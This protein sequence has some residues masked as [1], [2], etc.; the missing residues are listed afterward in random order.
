MV[1][2]ERQPGSLVRELR[3]DGPGAI[4]VHLQAAKAEDRRLPEA[5]R[6]G[7]VDTV[8]GVVAHV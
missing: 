6:A 8:A 1:E 7:G 5:T 3:L 4:L 2:L